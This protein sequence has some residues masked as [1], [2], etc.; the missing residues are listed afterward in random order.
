M[1]YGLSAT[2]MM[3][4]RI[5]FASTHEQGSPSCV[6]ASSKVIV[7]LSPLSKTRQSAAFQETRIDL[8]QD[9]IVGGTLALINQRKKPPVLDYLAIMP[10]PLLSCICV[11]NGMCVGSRISTASVETREMESIM[12]NN[13]LTSSLVILVWNLM[14]Q[15][16]AG[17]V[18]FDF[19]L[20]LF[21]MYICTKKGEKIWR[22]HSGHSALQHFC[23]VEQFY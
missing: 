9:G 13:T 2:L 22:R 21:V 11:N 14:V 18:N 5:S 19:T 15:G 12:R 16:V 8:Q 1:T 3:L 17:C 7:D 10:S 23:N 4:T 6:L 20:L